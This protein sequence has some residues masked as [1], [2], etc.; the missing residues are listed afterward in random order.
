MYNFPMKKL[1]LI[2]VLFSLS[3]QS[4]FA[5][6]LENF[7]SQRDERAVKRL[8]Q[9][10]VRYAN[11]TNFKKF[12]ST[13]DASYMNSDGFDYDKYSNLVKDTWNAF[14]NIKYDIEIKKVVAK[15]GCATADVI[16]HSYAKL[17]S[18][19]KELLGELRGESICVYSLKKVNGKWKVIS[20]AILDE[21]TS[22]MY[23]E[24]KNLDVKLTVPESVEAETEYTA[25]LEFV[26]PE[27]TMA[28]ASIAADVVEYPQ[29]PTKEVF[30]TMPS[31]N[32]LERLFVANNQSKNEYIVAS[33]GLTKAEICDISMKLSLTGYGYKMK[34]VSVIQ[35]KDELSSDENK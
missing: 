10:Q 18:Q 12:I 11:S 6:N 17:P 4:S 22:M 16:E 19:T 27:E 24:A 23:G 28:I 29:S 13:Y 32:I 33:I 35:K 7:N 9:S 3:L 31:D 15:D 8:L 20:D 25:S 21:T 2:I 30:R 34:R 1:F 26:P 14:S 5:W